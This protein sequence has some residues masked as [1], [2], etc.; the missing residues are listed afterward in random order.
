MLLD[1]VSV[2]FADGVFKLL[3]NSLPPLV[4][5]VILLEQLS[6]ANGLQ[7]LQQKHT[8]HRSARCHVPSYHSRHAANAATPHLDHG[9]LRL[10]H[11][12]NLTVTQELS[13]HHMQQGLP[14]T[15]SPNVMM[16]PWC[17]RVIMHM[18][19]LRSCRKVQ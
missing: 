18:C 11:N 3:E 14:A 13:A 8:H 9:V 17:Q 6:L 5:W 7:P 1:W 4:H 12:Q 10:M 19:C 15:M 2:S 16:M